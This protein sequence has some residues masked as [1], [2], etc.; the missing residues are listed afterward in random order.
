MQE[1]RVAEI[2]CTKCSNET[3]KTA[4]QLTSGSEVLHTGC[5]Q[6]NAVHGHGALAELVNQTQCAGRARGE[7]LGHL[8][9]VQRKGRLRRRHRLRAEV[10]TNQ[11]IIQEQK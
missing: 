7:H 11:R 10:L 5:Q 8:L 2:T 3:K 1:G 9:Q 4:I 6:S